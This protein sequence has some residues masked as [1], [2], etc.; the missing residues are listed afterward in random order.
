MMCQ[1]G[2]PLAEIGKFFGVDR[3]TIF[4][5]VEW[6]CQEKITNEVLYFYKRDAYGMPIEVERE[7]VAPS[8]EI[9]IE[10]QRL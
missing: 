10:R 8:S 4:R 6:Y 3:S 2:M 1:S 9:R 5:W 7:K